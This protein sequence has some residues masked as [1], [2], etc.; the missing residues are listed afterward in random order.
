MPK[1]HASQRSPSNAQKKVAAGEDLN[2]KDK[3][4]D[5]IIKGKGSSF[6]KGRKHV[7]SV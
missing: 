5:N 6:P 4:F 7:F 2:E 3:L 1:P